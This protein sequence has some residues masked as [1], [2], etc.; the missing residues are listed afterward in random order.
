MILG[1]PRPSGR[2]SLNPAAAATRR[3]RR[4]DEMTRSLALFLALA[5][6]AALPGAAL[7]Q[8]PPPG[9]TACAGC[10]AG[11]EHALPSLRSLSA[12]DIADAMTA[13]RTGAREATVMD[14]IARGFDDAETQAIASWLAAQARKP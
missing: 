14:R 12:Q 9:A 8:T 11:P 5:A 7:A 6:C 2:G 1:A 10:H 13:F 3:G 4:K